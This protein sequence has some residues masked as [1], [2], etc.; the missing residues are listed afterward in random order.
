[1]T[2]TPDRTPGNKSIQPQRSLGAETSS[3]RSLQEQE[4]TATETTGSRSA[5]QQDPTGEKER[6]GDKKEKTPTGTQGKFEGQY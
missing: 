6:G 1:M 2:A 5:Q 4:R 3:G